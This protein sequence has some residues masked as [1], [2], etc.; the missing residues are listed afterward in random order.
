MKH[1]GGSATVEREIDGGLETLELATPAVLSVDL[2]IN[3]PRY[4]TLPNI[5]KAKKKKVKKTTPKKLGVEAAPTLKVTKVEEPAAR[6]AGEMVEDVDTLIGKL[7][8][9]GRI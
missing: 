2:R 6:A 7:K 9:A 4:A 5:M 3:Q 1:G 8:D